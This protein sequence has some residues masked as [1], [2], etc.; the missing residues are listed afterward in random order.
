MLS[1]VPEIKTA[2]SLELG[3]IFL[4]III[5]APEVFRRNLIVL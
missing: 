3:S 2:L 4:A 5:V 1:E